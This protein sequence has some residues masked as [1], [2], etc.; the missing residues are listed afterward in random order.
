MPRRLSR[1]RIPPEKLIDWRG[2]DYCST[3]F[4]LLPHSGI[5]RDKVACLANKTSPARAFPIFVATK[6]SGGEGRGG[7]ARGT[8]FEFYARPHPDLLPEEK[9]QLLRV[10][11][12]SAD[13]PINPAARI[14]KGDG[15]RFS[16]N[17]SDVMFERQWR[18]IC[19]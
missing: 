13:R 9:E 10:S 19:H 18:D 8:K 7:V 11:V 6:P 1:G 3:S 5:R 17:A 16:G 4:V 15:E 12:L 2:R 14:F